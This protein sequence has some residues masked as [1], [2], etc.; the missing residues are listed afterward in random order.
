VA[1]AKRAAKEAVKPPKKAAAPRPAKD[2]DDSSIFGDEG[3]PI[4]GHDH[5]ALTMKVRQYKQLFGDNPQ[6]KKFR[7]KKNASVPELQA[8][9]DELD[10]IVSVSTI[11]DFM[12][13]AI[14]A[15]IRVAEGVSART[16]NYNVTG[17]SAMLRMNKEFLTLCKLCA[18]KYGAYAA[19]P[20]EVQLLFIVATSAFICTQTNAK[21]AQIN[22]FL[23]QPPM[24]MTGPPP[25]INVPAPPAVDPPAPPASPAEPAL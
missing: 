20:P 1:A 5:R 14:I 7:V 13:E 18:V 16:Q 15:S 19:A 6:V 25:V 22:A 3:T 21:K 2:D 8:A 23:D 4:V 9:I 12:T 11:D 17:L 24:Q 10:S